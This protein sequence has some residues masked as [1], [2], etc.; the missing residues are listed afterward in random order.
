MVHIIEAPGEKTPASLA[1]SSGAPGNVRTH[2]MTAL[3]R[4]EMK[5]GILPSCRRYSISFA[6]ICKRRSKNAAGDGAVQSRGTS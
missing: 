6:L 3:T 4:D 1:L 2:T 5:V